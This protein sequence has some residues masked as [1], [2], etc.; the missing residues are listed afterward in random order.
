MSEFINCSICVS[1]IPRDRIKMAENG[2]KYISICVSERKEVDSYGNTHTIFMAQ[3]KEEREAKAGK[4]Y[5][6]SGKAY[7]PSP[8]PVTSQDIEAMPSIAETDDLPF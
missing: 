2:K 1:D 4:N 6:G 7:N 8:T 5:I 3:S